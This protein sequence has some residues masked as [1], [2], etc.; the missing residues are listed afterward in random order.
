[1]RDAKALARMLAERAPSLARELIPNGYRRGHEWCSGTNRARDNFKVH[2][3]G[4]K[5]GVW[6]DFTSGEGGDALDLVAALLYG[7]NV[8]EAMAWARRW[9]GLGDGPIAAPRPVAAPAEAATPAADAEAE[10]RRGAARRMWLAGRADL[11]GTPVDAYLAGRGI[12]LAELARQPGAV[13][14]HL[15]LWNTE[16]QRPWPAMVAAIVG[17]DGRH[18]ATHRTWLHRDPG[19]RWS[20]APLHDP[21]MTL[22]R[23]V[24]GHIPLARGASG[25]PL[26]DAP[27]GEAVAIAEGI[28]TA[29]S[30]AVACPELRVL[31]AVS[32]ANMARVVLPDAVRE[33]IL[34]ADN[35]AAGSPAALAFQRAVDAFAAQGR[36]VRVARSPLGKDFNDALT[37]ECD[38]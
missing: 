16:S 36:T 32:L 6:S 17:P 15:E 3:S 26:A 14:F 24:G 11:L 5:A 35:D 1:M 20:K 13:R 38:A 18:A 34:C 19:G 37:M 2:L 21:K 27:E 25:K 30:V 10:G 23:Y 4:N 9:L 22:G 12:E 7:G 31:A 33:V 28:E 29:L 8:A